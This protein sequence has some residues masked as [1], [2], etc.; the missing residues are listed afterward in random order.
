MHFPSLSKNNIPAIKRDRFEVHARGVR[1]INTDAPI[2]PENVAELEKVADKPGE[3]DVIAL[4]REVQ[5]RCKY[6]LLVVDKI[7]RLCQMI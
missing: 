2:F 3:L 6:S 1:P 7:E 4:I 5:F